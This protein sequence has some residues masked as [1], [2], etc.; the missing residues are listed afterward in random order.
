M[1]LLDNMTPFAAERTW[2]RDQGGAEI[3]IV[4]VRCSFVIE[5]DGKQV[6]APDQAEVSRVPKFSGEPGLSSLVD[7]CDLVHTKKKT[8]V[9]VYGCAYSPPGK[10][11]TR[12]DVRL[13]VA[14]IDKT[15]RVHGDRRWEKS[16]IGVDLSAA[17]PFTQIPI[18]Y[19][20]A[21][22]GTDRKDPDPKK[23]R[24]QRY[25][26]IGTGFATRKEHLVN[27]A[28][29]NIEYPNRPYKDW[30]TGHPAGFGPIARHWAPRVGFAGTYNGDWENTRKPLLPSDFDE[31]FYQCAPEDQQVDGFLKGGEVVELRS[32]TPDGFLSFRLPRISLSFSTNFYD[33]TNAQHRAVFHTL[34]LYPDQRRFE[35]VWHS[36]LP[37][38]HKV[39]KL[40][41]TRIRLKRRINVPSDERRAGMWGGE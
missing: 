40:K 34:N 41:E 22:G 2:V 24:W 29:P 31:L 3:W 27:E 25:N 26:P 33:G 28:G 6:L 23:H 36:Q 11:T 9:L 21:Y 8:D 4:A 35:M 18:V 12:Q 10:T 16:L 20:R 37:S 32:L 39:N 5:A 7:E 38:H 14:Q 17:E 30:E 15:L 1:W 13:K 19:E